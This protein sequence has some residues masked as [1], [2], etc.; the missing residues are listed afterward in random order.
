VEIIIVG[1]VVRIKDELE[2]MQQAART[3]EKKRLTEML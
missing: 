2:Q 3:L 1:E